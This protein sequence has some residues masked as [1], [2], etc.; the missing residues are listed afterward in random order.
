MRRRRSKGVCSAGNLLPNRLPTCAH[1]TR[2][3]TTSPYAAQPNPTRW[4]SGRRTPSSRQS[5][6]TKRLGRSF[7]PD[8][9]PSQALEVLVRPRDDLVGDLAADAS[10]DRGEPAERPAVDQ[11]WRVRNDSGGLR[12][13]VAGDLVD[14]GALTVGFPPSR[15]NETR[16]QPDASVRPQ[17]PFLALGTPVRCLPVG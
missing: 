16:R 4:T 13:E 7:Y 8:F 15:F 6:S 10:A 1:L 2:P 14:L 3:Q 11:P 17:E 5:G 12:V 9:L